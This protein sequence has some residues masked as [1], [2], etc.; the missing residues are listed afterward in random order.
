MTNEELIEIALE[1]LTDS[2]SKNKEPDISPKLQVRLSKDHYRRA[3]RVYGSFCN[4]EDIDLVVAMK[5]NSKSVPLAYSSY[6]PRLREGGHFLDFDAGSLG[7]SNEEFDYIK[8]I[9]GVEF[10]YMKYIVE[11]LWAWPWEKDEFDFKI[12]DK[13]QKRIKQC[14]GSAI[15]KIVTSCRPVYCPVL[16]GTIDF[17]PSGPQLSKKK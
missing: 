16:G 11:V 2:I 7:L 4:I 12:S 9:D 13:D 10:G 3:E 8:N 6:S 15:K 1:E 14:Y 17:T 5:P